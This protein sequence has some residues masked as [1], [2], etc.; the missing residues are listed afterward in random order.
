MY[1]KRTRSTLYG[2]AGVW[3]A[4]GLHVAPEGASIAKHGRRYSFDTHATLGALAV[5]AGQVLTITGGGAPIGQLPLLDATIHVAAGGTL[6]LNTLHLS[7]EVSAET[8]AVVENRGSLVRTQPPSL[9]VPT[10][11][12]GDAL[13]P[14]DVGEPPSIIYQ[15]QADLDIQ[16]MLTCAT[17]GGVAAWRPVLTSGGVLFDGADVS[18]WL[19]A[20]GS[21]LPGMY[22]LRLAGDAMA[23]AVAAA[24]VVSPF[25]DVRV[26]STATGGSTLTF[27]SSVTLLADAALSF[28]GSVGVGGGVLGSAMWSSLNAGTVS[29]AAGTGVMAVSTTG[30]TAA[31]SGS[32]PGTVTV[33]TATISRE[34]SAAPTVSD[35]SALTGF[36]YVDSWSSGSVTNANGATFTLY[37]MPGVSGFTGDAAGADYYQAICAAAGL[38]TLGA[39]DYADNCAAWGC[40][41]TPDGTDSNGD[42]WGSGSDVDDNVRTNTGWTDYAVLLHSYNDGH[43]NGYN[44][45]HTT[46]A[47]AGNTYYPVCITET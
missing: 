43:P 3:L 2:D 26:L 41:P 27:E 6:V 44:N 20:I 18:A 34:G 37:L 7:R 4:L 38:S 40:L 10:A 13:P 24:F 8:D 28:S 39:S 35:P 29:F 15:Y 1:W 21:G 47:L 12:A 31:M 25:Q 17:V 5:T 45:D 42:Y 16:T 46:A 32:L 11:E 33:G 22:V 30:A 19:A 36:V 14:C 23:W 9:R